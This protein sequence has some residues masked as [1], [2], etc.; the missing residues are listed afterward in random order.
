MI[1]TKHLS[2][3][4][5]CQRFL[6]EQLDIDKLHHQLSL[7]ILIEKEKMKPVP[8]TPPVE[9][10]SEELSEESVIEKKVI[11]IGGGEFSMGINHQPTHTHPPYS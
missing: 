3:N 10:S 2:Q 8:V 1:R 4:E 7:Q 6:K 5:L 11:E 9:E